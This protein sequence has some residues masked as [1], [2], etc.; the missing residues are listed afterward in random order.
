MGRLS[1]RTLRSAAW[2]MVATLVLAHP[3]LGVEYAL[4]KK[5]VNPLDDNAA[6]ADRFGESITEVGDQILIGARDADLGA[7]SAGAVFVFDRNGQYI[8]T[9]ENPMPGPN[10]DDWFGET[11]TAVGDDKVLI[12][13]R[14]DDA[15]GEN[16]GAAYLFARGANCCTPAAHRRTRRR[17][18][19]CATCRRTA[20]W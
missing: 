7:Q 9:I 3:A 10:K 12:S 16:A 6:I 14:N 19:R 11:M 18:Q 15:D 1:K 20:I 2:L 17:I 4:L 13:S 5:I 8:R